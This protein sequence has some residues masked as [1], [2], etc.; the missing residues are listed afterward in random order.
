VATRGYLEEGRGT[1]EAM[2]S[3]RVFG[4]T[5]LSYEMHI[6]KISTWTVHGVV[7]GCTSGANDAAGMQS[8]TE[9]K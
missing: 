8:P 7:V 5:C 4:G 1:G 3:R 6:V 2:V 9:V